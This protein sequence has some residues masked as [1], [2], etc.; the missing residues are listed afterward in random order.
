MWSRPPWWK[1]SGLDDVGRRAVDQST[2][3]VVGGVPA[4]GVR[5]LP[6]GVDGLLHH[7]APVDLVARLLTI[8]PDA[9]DRDGGH[10]G[11]VA[12]RGFGLLT[13][14]LDALVEGLDRDAPWHPAVAV[15]DG[16]ADRGR[17][18]PA[19]PDRDVARVLGHGVDVD[20]VE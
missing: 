9:G 16:A 14:L 4:A 8:A 15:L 20:V 6:L 7:L 19:V 13:Q 18:V 5:R 17:G 1:R 11:H 10:S 2:V 12:S 3:E